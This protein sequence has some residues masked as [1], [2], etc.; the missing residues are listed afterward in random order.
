MPKRI[1]GYEKENLE[2][3][4]VEIKIHSDAEKVRVMKTVIND[5]I[6]YD[7]NS[8]IIK[9]PRNNVDEETK[10]IREKALDFK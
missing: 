5:E 3:S 10:L 6:L 4:W 9:T 1:L 2:S 7:R 8:G